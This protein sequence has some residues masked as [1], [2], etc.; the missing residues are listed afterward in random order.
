VVRIVIEFVFGGLDG[1]GGWVG[2]WVGRELKLTLL[3]IVA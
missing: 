3:L 2:G 1:M